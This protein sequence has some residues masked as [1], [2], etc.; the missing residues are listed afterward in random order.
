VVEIAKQIA[1]AKIVPFTEDPANKFT[2]GEV[3]IA[4]LYQIGNLRTP[5][6]IARQKNS[7]KAA[8]NKGEFLPT[9]Q[10]IIDYMGQ[11]QAVNDFIDTNFPSGLHPELFD[12]RAWEVCL[13]TAE[14]HILT[15]LLHVGVPSLLG[16]SPTHLEAFKAVLNQAA[17]RP[18]T[19]K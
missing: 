2:A 5:D 19:R 1:P 4:L 11:E 12:S 14:N 9:Q 8:R 10:L 18:M 17:K 16:N 15:S 7:A 13:E 3:G 6:V